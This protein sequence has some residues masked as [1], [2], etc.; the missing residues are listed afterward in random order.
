MSRCWGFE[1]LEMKGCVWE[2]PAS[3]HSLCRLPNA[4]PST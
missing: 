3:P 4:M 2:V 1:I